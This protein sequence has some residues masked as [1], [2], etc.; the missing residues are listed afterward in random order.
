MTAESP[1]TPAA[2]TLDGTMQQIN[3]R[4]K[5]LGDLPIFSASVNRV[6]LVSSQVDSDAM[7]L[8]VEVMKDANLTTKLLRLANSTYYN[9][10]V[11][12]IKSVSRAVVLLGFETVKNMCITLKLIESFHHEHPGIDL[13]RL[14]V[15]AYLAAG[16]VREMAAKGGLADIEESYLCGLLHGLGEII[17][18]Y[19]LPQCYQQMQ[20]ARD[21]GEQRWSEVQRKLLGGSFA[22]IGQYL[23]R[24]WEFPMSVVQS[25]AP[26]RHQ[27]GAV[28]NRDELNHALAAMSHTVLEQLYL[29]NPEQL[30][31]D[32]A[33]TLVAL[34]DAAG[35]GRAEVEKS[36]TH[37]FRESCVLADAFG[38]DSNL[39]TPTLT[40]S[41]DEV[42]ERTCRQFAYYASTRKE[43]PALT[44][45]EIAEPVEPEPAAESPATVP[46]KVEHAPASCE[47]DPYLQLQA[48]QEITSLI[49]EQAGVHRVFGKV[50]EVMHK[51]IGFAR[52]CMCLLNSDQ[53]QLLARLVQGDEPGV[54]KDY[55]RL[56]VRDRE[57]VFIKVLLEGNDMLVNDID[58]ASLG[59]IIPPAYFAKVAANG[60][61]VASVRAGTRPVG[62]FYADNGADGARITH[63]A[64]RSFLQFVN[65]ARLALQYAEM[66]RSG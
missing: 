27:G 48:L 54:L 31:A 60:F 35:I 40:D 2:V 49:T 37:S 63:A 13:D 55:F 52:V 61:M 10:G 8:A 57:N 28:R 66:Q 26:Y 12:R 65:Q 36:L 30:E 64:Q 47:P 46:A 3:R 22:E 6:R 39:L 25:M 21:A 58:A 17:V 24:S 5:Q 43:E 34:G 1:L 45:L 7:K 9:R 50:V 20:Q 44:N 53:N 41:E 16:F 14:L 19:T 33:T 4:L 56:P 29:D 32:F 62:L 18:A 42:L 38:L 23:T 59:A 15:S 11:G 51:G